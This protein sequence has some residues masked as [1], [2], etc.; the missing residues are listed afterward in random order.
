MTHCTQ[1]LS[2]RELLA[3]CANGFGSLALAS[4]MAQDSARAASENPLAPKPPH[5]PA[6]ARSVIFLFMEG[7]PS[8]MDSF[9]PKP[10]LRVDHGKPIPELMG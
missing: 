7:G 8:Q 6:K 3:R 4:L 1:P 10:R 2:R 9:D 5:F